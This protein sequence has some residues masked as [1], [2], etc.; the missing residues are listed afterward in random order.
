MGGNEGHNLPSGALGS[1]FGDLEFP[2]AMLA[3]EARVPV[4]VN[5]VDR[6]RAQARVVTTLNLGSLLVAPLL[7]AGVVD[8]V[9]LFSWQGGPPSV[10]AAA[11]DFVAKVA[12]LVALAVE[13]D[14]LRQIA[15]NEPAS[16]RSGKRGSQTPHTPS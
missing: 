16:K 5:I 9:V 10:D 11:T 13:N 2:Q 1:Q 7:V 14:R 3:S 4:A 12:A 6:P 8:G 15:P